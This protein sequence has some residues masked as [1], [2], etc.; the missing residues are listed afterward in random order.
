MSENEIIDPIN[1]EDVPISEN[2]PE[3]PGD[4]SNQPSEVPSTLEGTPAAPEGKKLQ[5]LRQRRH[6]H[7]LPVEWTHSL[8]P[9]LL[10]GNLQAHVLILFCLFVL[11]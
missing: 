6:E 7:I 5:P 9:K 8:A 3:V 1:P 4:D 10:K 11:W 2:N